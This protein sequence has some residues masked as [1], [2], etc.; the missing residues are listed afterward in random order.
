M[1]A[2]IESSLHIIHCD[3]D[4]FFAAV[5]QNDNPLLQGQ[6]VIVGGSADS[7]GVVSTCSYEARRFGVRSAMPIA[8]ARQLCPVGVYLPVRM[9]RYIEISK[10]VFAILSKYTPL[11]EPLS[12]DEA[13]LDVKGTGHLFGTPEHIGREI[14]RRVKDETGLTISVG[15]SFNKFLAKLASELGKPDGLF[16]IPFEPAIQILRPLPVTRLWGVGDKARQSLARFGLKTIGDIQD[17]PPGWLAERLGS[18][19]QHYWELAHGNDARQVEI[20]E[21]RKSLGR[22]ITFPEDVDDI[23]TLQNALA[24]FA[25]ELCRKLRR[26]KLY[27]STVTLKLRYNTFKTITRSRT[28]APSHADLVIGQVAEE[29]LHKSYSGESPIRL[30]GLSLGRLSSVPDWQQGDLF[31]V[32]GQYEVVDNVMDQIRQRFGSRAIQRG[33]QLQRPEDG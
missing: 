33:N 28:I 23:P 24:A 10:Q 15:I 20:N 22:E 14:K 27:C 18:S 29:L 30:I 11:M 17:L 8:R 3:L 16:I 25:A 7:R 6:P 19:G 1:A 26:D 4:A 32:T 9:S 12:I 31:E 13:F 2:D 21:E 5:E